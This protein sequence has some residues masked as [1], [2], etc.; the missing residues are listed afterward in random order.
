MKNIKNIFVHLARLACVMLLYDRPMKEA[1]VSASQGS[2]E[3]F[4]NLFILLYINF[5]LALH[6]TL[7]PAYR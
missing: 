5:V 4:Y 3:A 7:H 6:F 2:F 1:S